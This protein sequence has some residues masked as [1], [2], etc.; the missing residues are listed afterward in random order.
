MDLIPPSYRSATDRDAWIIIA[1]YIPSSDLY[2][3]SLVCHRWHGLFMPFLWGD[4]AS[5]FGTNNDV[6][7]GK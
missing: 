5:H 6:V 3:A 1:R 2:A 4:P 7:Y